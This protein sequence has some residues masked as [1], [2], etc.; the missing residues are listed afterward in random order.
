[1]QGTEQI[2]QCSGDHVVPGTEI[3][4]TACKPNALYPTYNFKAWLC[5]ILV[6]EENLFI[7]C[8]ILGFGYTWWRSGVIPGSAFKNLS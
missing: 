5:H 2:I 1:M 8:F 4:L 7:S 6:S 3:G